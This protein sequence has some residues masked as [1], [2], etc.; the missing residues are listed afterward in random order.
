M[1]FTDKVPTALTYGGKQFMIV[2]D[3]NIALIRDAVVK[4]DGGIIHEAHIPLYR[5]L[6]ISPMMFG[7]YHGNW[8]YWVEQ[9]TPLTLSSAEKE[10]LRSAIEAV[11]LTRTK[12]SYA[13]APRLNP[14][15]Q[16]IFGKLN[17]TPAD[18]GISSSLTWKNY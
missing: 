12:P 3:T 9:N 6:G 10:T 17:I 2:S 13:L 14:A 8:D 1:T 7:Y 15:A 18:L 4:K 11:L 5:E 16:E